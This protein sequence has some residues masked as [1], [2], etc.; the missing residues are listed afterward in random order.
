M[1][2]KITQVNTALEEKPA[3][4]NKVPED[5]SAGGGWLAKVEVD[6]ASIKEYEGLMDA[7]AYQAFT[8]ETAE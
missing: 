8:Q 2:C 3:I 7:D 5:D 4:I 6:D 1:R